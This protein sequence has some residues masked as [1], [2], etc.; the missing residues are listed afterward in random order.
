MAT[1]T[2]EPVLPRFG[3]YCSGLDLTRKLAPD[4]VRQVIDAMDTWG[5]TVW[6]DTGMSDADHVEFSRNFGYLEQVPAREG[7]TYRLPFRELFD[8]SNLNSA[9][10]ITTDPAA[11]R[12]T[13]RYS[14]LMPSAS[15]ARSS[16]ARVSQG[17]RPVKNGLP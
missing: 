15:N 7:M 13:W 16:W 14:Y 6:R 11:L 4:E 5:V 2:V 12:S 8:A 10:E 3:G 9:G 1:L 17:G